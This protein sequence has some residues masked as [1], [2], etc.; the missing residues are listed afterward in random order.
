MALTFAFIGNRAD[1]G[2]LI[3]QAVEGSLT[4]TLNSIS[5]NHDASNAASPPDDATVSAKSNDQLAWGVGFYQAD[6]VLLR[7]RPTESRSPFRLADELREIRCHALLAHV[8]RTKSGS[9]R[10]ETTPP[11]RFGNLLFA[12]QGTSPHLGAIRTSVSDSL[13]DFL[14]SHLKGDTFTE[15]A[16][17]IFLAELP[18]PDL[19]R[20][21]SRSSRPAF[22]MLEPEA[23]RTALRRTFARL[24]RFT[25]ETKI[26]RFNGGIWVH[27][28]EHTIVAHR[29]GFLALR[30]YKGRRELEEAITGPRTPRESLHIGHDLSQF[31]A[32]LGGAEVLAPGWERLPDGIVLTATRTQAPETEA[33][34]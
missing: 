5:S 23:I 1:L 18:R 26:D 28:G 22:G 32:L 16:G 19:E 9:L 4:V 21:W 3:P 15:L 17:S 13:P 7:R 24:D 11:L 14:R 10:T 33:L 34:G 8:C 25:E 20:T 30:V 2:P 6:E 29:S 27:T 31:T 12:C